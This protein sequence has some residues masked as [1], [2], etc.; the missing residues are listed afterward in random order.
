MQNP[1]ILRRSDGYERT[2]LGALGLLAASIEALVGGRAESYI[3]ELKKSRDE[4][5]RDLVNEA[6]KLGANAVVGVDFETSKI[7]EGI[8]VAATGTTVRVVPEQQGPQGK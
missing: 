5:V 4:A 8:I 6:W 7:L 3:S 2:N 1:Q